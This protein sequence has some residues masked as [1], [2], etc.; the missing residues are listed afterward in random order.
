MKTTLSLL[1]VT[2]S[3]LIMG[4]PLPP[5]VS[6]QRSGEYERVDGWPTTPRDIGAVPAV[7]VDAHGHVHVFRR[8]SPNVWTFD[9][10]GTLIREW[11]DEIAEWA[12]SIRVDHDGYIWTVDGGGHQIKKWSPDGN[13]LLLTLGELGVEGAGR[14]SF[15]RPADVAVGPGGDF[16]VADG[17][18][19]S[20][21][22]KYDRRGKFVKEWGERGV[23]PGQFHTVHAIVVGSDGRVFVADRE[24]NRVQ[25]FDSEGE[26]IDEWTHV[27]TPYGL[28]ITSEGLIYVA[29]LP[30]GTVWI[31][32]AADG[33]IQGAI[34]GTEGIH[35]VGVGADGSVYAASV[36]GT[37]VRK[38]VQ[39][40]P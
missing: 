40:N 2:A 29:D 35:W 16:F 11:G 5:E 21:V 26:F 13:E 23:E 10:E 25:I 1:L 39:S 30:G 36:R 4:A 9:S 31:A 22:V 15:N 37:Y 28:Y 20:R 19:N 33:E 38:F 3:A 7:D 6:T 17:Y 14:Y 12:H 34:E 24:N 18:G 27:G 32:S 8:E